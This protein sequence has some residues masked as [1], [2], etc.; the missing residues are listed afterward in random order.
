MLIVFI[1]GKSVLVRA[2]VS[3]CTIKLNEEEAKA[4]TRDTRHEKRE[5]RAESCV[6]TMSTVTN[7]N[8][9]LYIRLHSKVDD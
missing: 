2:F 7:H 9:L 5:T 1:Y 8:L 4:E 6:W 3:G